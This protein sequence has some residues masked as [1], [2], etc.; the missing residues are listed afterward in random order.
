MGKLA[1]QFGK[2]SMPERAVAYYSSRGLPGRQLTALAGKFMDINQ[3]K[4]D[5]HIHIN[6][7]T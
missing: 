2:Y 1:A 4:K 6:M 5:Y 3:P 7:T